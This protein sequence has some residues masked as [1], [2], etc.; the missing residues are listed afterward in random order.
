MCTIHSRTILCY[1]QVVIK[2]S[3]M[4]GNRKGTLMT[5]IIAGYYLLYLFS[6]YPPTHLFM[7]TQRRLYTIYKLC[8]V[9]RCV[10]TQH[11]YSSQ[12]ILVFFQVLN[13][14]NKVC[15]LMDSILLS[16]LSSWPWHEET[17]A[18]TGRQRDGETSLSSLSLLFHFTALVS[19]IIRLGSNMFRLNC[20]S[21]TFT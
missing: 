2:I 9:Y 17:A 4:Q 13:E 5:V 15:S 18:P 20:A 14:V 10:F 1:Y 21:H 8:C 6:I 19:D 3:N 16:M 7:T 11:S 12:C